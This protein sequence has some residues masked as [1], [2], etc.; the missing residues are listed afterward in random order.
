[1]ILAITALAVFRITRL[2]VYDDI[3][4]RPR[5]WLSMQAKWVDSLLSCVWCAGFWISVL[6]TWGLYA[7]DAVALPVLVWY[8]LP[9]AFS[10]IAGIVDSWV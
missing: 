6:A 8:L 7:T 2:V 1:M 4:Y 10:A 3:A 9:F 5:I